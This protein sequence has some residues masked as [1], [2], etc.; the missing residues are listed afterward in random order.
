MA[1]NSSSIKL[2]IGTIYKKTEN[3]N[4]F[5][6]YQINGQRKAVSLKTK[7]KKEAIAKANDLVPIAKA[8]SVEVVSAHVKQAKNLVTKRQSLLLSMAWDKYSVH[9]ERAM[10]ATVH[11][12]QS[13]EY[14][15]KEFINYIADSNISL[16]D[17]TPKIAAQYVE[18]LKTTKIAVET[19]NKKI[20]RLR[21]IFKTLKSYYIGKNPFG[22][23]NL[24]RK[25]REERDQGVMRLS[26]NKEQIQ[27]IKDVLDDENYKL[28]NKEEIKVVY[29][30]GM[31]TG[32]RLKDCV[33]LRWNKVDLKNRLIYVQQFKTGKEV[34]IP[35]AKQLFE[36]LEQAKEW[37]ENTHSYV[38]PNVAKRYN[39][40]DDNGKNIGSNLVSKD[41]LRVIPWIGLEPSIE[42]P[43]RKK[44]VT[45]YGFHSLRHTF[46]SICA[47]VG[48]PKAVVVSIIGTDSDII[49]KHYTHVG[50]EAQLKAIEAISGEKRADPQ[51]KINKII[52]Y[53]NY[54]DLDGNHYSEIRNIINN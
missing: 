39:G 9:P 18:H 12:Q 21:R 28:V 53:L 4:Y 25:L 49:D 43:G 15:L 47:E 31:Y 1:K 8:S 14:S 5:F 42:V 24:N 40:I 33:L 54:H 36:V 48:V 7:N 16:E 23:S 38:C 35:I 30:I 10:P 46:V 22:S 34:V 19:H 29:Y 52:D 41:V 2:D 11:E 20:R 6:R 32:Q 51:E 17:I 27:A 37:Q 50:A 26:F 3:G 44:K 13:Y 45:V